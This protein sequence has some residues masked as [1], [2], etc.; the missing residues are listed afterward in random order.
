METTVNG[1]L[2]LLMLIEEALLNLSYIQLIQSNTDGITLKIKEKELPIYLDIC[3]KWEKLTRLQ[4]EHAFYDKMIVADV[5]SYIGIYKDN[6]KSP[7]CKGR[8]E[9]ED[10]QNY[11][12]THLHKNKSNLIVPKAIYAYFVNGIKPEKYLE[13]N[14]NIYDYCSG[15]KAKGDWRFY[16]LKITKGEYTETKLNKIVRY[17]ISNN[18]CKI[19]KRSPDGREIQTESGEWMQTIFNKF[20]DKKWEDYNVNERYYLENIYKEIN[21]IEPIEEN[22]PKQLTF[23]LW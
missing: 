17:Y 1:Q 3:S 9:W 15:V 7:K 10:L 11:K 22:K 12:A 18:G 16:E 4:L 8:F 6:I 19:V 2:L 21:N 13:D 23:D 20:Q 14:R 5:N